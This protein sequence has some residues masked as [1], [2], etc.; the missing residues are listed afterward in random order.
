VVNGP[1]VGASIGLALA[2]DI[3]IASRSAYFLPAFVNIGLVPDSGVSSL[4]TAKLGPGRAGAAMMLGERISAEDAERWGLIWKCVADEELAGE[5]AAL[6]DKLSSGPTRTYAAIKKLTRSAATNALSEQMQIEAE[7][8]A[9]IRQTRDTQEAKQA[10]L[11]RRKPVF[12]G[13]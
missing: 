4:L 3:V 13:S 9:Q 1:C 2:C 7:T 12:T 11:E 8:Q 5:A 10:F 6:T